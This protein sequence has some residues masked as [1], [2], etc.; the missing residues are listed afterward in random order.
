MRP[1]FFTK[2]PSQPWAQGQQGSQK[3]LVSSSR[4]LKL[5]RVGDPWSQPQH[6]PSSWWRALHP[7]GEPASIKGKFPSLPLGIIYQ[8]KSYLRKMLGIEQM[9]SEDFCNSEWGMWPGRFVWFFIFFVGLFIISI[10]QFYKD[11][12][13]GEMSEAQAGW[14][15]G[16]NGWKDGW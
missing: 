3:K 8:L 11:P 10:P 9:T 16:G 6:V 12:R 2:V 1:G 7:D 15:H 13:A 5:P 14:K 4:R